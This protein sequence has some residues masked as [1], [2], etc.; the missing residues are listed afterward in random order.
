MRGLDWFLVLLLIVGAVGSKAIKF[1][2]IEG[3]E[4]RS[5]SSIHGNPRRPA[6]LGHVPRAW[7]METK[8]WLIK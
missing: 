5:S 3:V 4:K 7:D 1:G 8:D 6:P 2:G